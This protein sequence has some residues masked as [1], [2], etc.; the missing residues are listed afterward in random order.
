MKLNRFTIFQS[1]IGC[2]G[3][4]TTPS[5]SIISPNYPNNYGHNTDCEWLIT[6]EERHSIVLTFVDFDVEGAAD[7]SYD[8]VVVC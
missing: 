3:N 6:V 4:F 5:G 8:Y 7:C 2:G 1:V